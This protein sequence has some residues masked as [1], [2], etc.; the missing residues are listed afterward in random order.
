MPETRHALSGYLKL[1]PAR[2]AS[3]GCTA[4]GIRADRRADAV[5]ILVGNVALLGRVRRAFLAE[6]ELINP[7]STNAVGQASE[8]FPH[9]GARMVF[10]EVRRENREVA[11]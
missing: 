4:P 11:E 5:S 8:A 7:P 9:L 10:W 2:H 3:R 1:D 6:P